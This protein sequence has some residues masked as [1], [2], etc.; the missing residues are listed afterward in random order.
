MVTYDASCKAFSMHLLLYASQ[1]CS[2]SHQHFTVRACWCIAAV[3]REER[4]HCGRR[5][6]VMLALKPS[7]R[8]LLFQR[9]FPQMFHTAVRRHLAFGTTTCSYFASLHREGTEVVIGVIKGI[10]QSAHVGTVRPPRA[11]RVLLMAVQT[12][13]CFMGVVL[14]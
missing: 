11:S 6:S 8:F 9:T 7:Q 1:T 4:P 14:V 5:C 12:W 3:E 10:G 13:P 2:E